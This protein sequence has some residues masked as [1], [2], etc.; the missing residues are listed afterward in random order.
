LLPLNVLI[1]NNTTKAVLEMSKEKNSMELSSSQ[2]AHKCSFSQNFPRLL[3]NKVS[4][5]SVVGIVTG[6]GLEDDGS[7]FES[8]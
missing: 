3:R 6:Y 7:E 2:G 5:V 1:S 4:L 8:R